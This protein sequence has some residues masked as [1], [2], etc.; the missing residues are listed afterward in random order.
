M[1]RVGLL[2]AGV[3]LVRLI[4]GLLLARVCA[5]SLG[6]AGFALL[7]TLSNLVVVVASLVQ[8]GAS[9]GMTTYA[10][11]AGAERARERRRVVRQTLARSIVAMLPLAIALWFAIEFWD[12]LA[13][14]PAGVAAVVAVFVLLSAPGGVLQGYFSGSGRPTVVMSAQVIAALAALAIAAAGGWQTS[15]SGSMRPSVPRRW[16]SRWF[17]AWHTFAKCIRARRRRRCRRRSKQ[18][19]PDIR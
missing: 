18:L 19:R 8:G 3:A 1:F 10:A 17:C 9:L 6:P 7:G 15:R 13:G 2:N 4:A 12:R 16:H 14:V 11:D 5:L